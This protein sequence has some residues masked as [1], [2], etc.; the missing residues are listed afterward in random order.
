MSSRREALIGKFRAGSLDRVRR[1]SLAL[2]DVR[3]GRGTT[4]GEQQIAR[5]LHTL[6][7]EATMLGFAGVGDLFRRQEMRL[8]R[9]RI[10]RCA[11]KPRAESSRPW[12]SCTSGSVEL[13]AAELEGGSRAAGGVRPAA[14]PRHKPH[15]EAPVSPRVQVFDSM[16]DTAEPTR[17]PEAREKRAP[18][19]PK[20][21]WV[22]V[23]ALR[24]DELSERVSVFETEYRALYV[25]LREFARRIGSDSADARAF[26]AMLT[27]FDRGAGSLQDITSVAWALRLV[28][29]EP[30]LSELAT[31]AKGL[32][33]A[34]G[35]SLS[36]SVNAGNAQ[37]EHCSR[38]HLKSRWSISCETPSIT[39]SRIRP[40][41]RA[42]AMHN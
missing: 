19:K 21:R 18:D 5:E 9:E 36:I 38:P 7:G 31:Y 40:I 11:A 17:T 28:P 35:K 8:E 34:Q 15:P 30:T 3:E 39:G 26:R 10:R 22:Q 12:P 37:I 24:I 32:A 25:R 27:E 33:S 2:S 29:V 41:A 14:T 20:E 13:S 23:N 6:K 4:E 16:G 42:R 1:L